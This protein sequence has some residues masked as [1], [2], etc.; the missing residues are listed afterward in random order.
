MLN[1]QVHAIAVHDAGES[2]GSKL[3]AVGRFTMAGSTTVARVARLD[4]TGWVD[5]GSPFANDNVFDVESL[6]N[7]DGSSVLWA[8]GAGQNV[9]AYYD[10]MSWTVV[11]TPPTTSFIR[12]VMS[13]DNGD[14]PA[15]YVC[16]SGGYVY[17]WNGTEWQ[18]PPAAVISVGSYFGD[19]VTFD[20]DGNGPDTAHLVHGSSGSSLVNSMQSPPNVLTRGLALLQGST[21][22]GSPYN[23]AWVKVVKTIDLGDGPKLYVSHHPG[24]GL[25]PARGGLSIWDGSAWS[26]LTHPTEITG[27]IYGVDALDHDH[28]GQPSLFGYSTVNIVGGANLVRHTGTQWVAAGQIS[29]IPD[30]SRRPRMVAGTDPC[31]GTDVLY[32]AP[33]ASTGTPTRISVYTTCA[34]C[35]F[36]LNRNGAADVSDIFDFLSHWSSYELCGDYNRDGSVLVQDIY[37]FLSGWYAGCSQ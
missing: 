30:I 27:T 24:P 34:R 1:D 22:F 10:G 32:V 14:G 33:L 7:P 31:N 36:D 35:P 12:E 25:P 15:I 4:A 11:P 26:G 8:V 9:A 16:N 6:T 18:T 20:A 23:F 3:Y 21:W 28:D 37:D 5:V 17:R 19:M 2:G 29:T 13:Y